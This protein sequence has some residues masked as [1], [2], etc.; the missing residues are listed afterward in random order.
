MVCEKYR[1]F[2]NIRIFLLLRLLYA[3]AAVDSA[4]AATAVDAAVAETAAEA[5]L[6]YLLGPV[7][8]SEILRPQTG[9][10]PMSY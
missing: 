4:D 2:L 3:S 9:V 8:E 7:I 1:K 5:V 10:L 6:Q